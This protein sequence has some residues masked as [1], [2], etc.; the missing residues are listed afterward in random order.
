MQSCEIQRFALSLHSV[1]LSKQRLYRLRRKILIISGVYMLHRNV[2]KGSNI[3]N[4]KNAHLQ[5]FQICLPPLEEQQRI[6]Q[7][8]EELFSSLDDILTAL[9]V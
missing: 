3:N 9:E 7:K 1:Y 2:A 6:V 5:N 4:V 8:I